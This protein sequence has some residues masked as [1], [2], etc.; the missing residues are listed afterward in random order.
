MQDRGTG[1]TAVAVQEGNSDVVEVRLAEGTR[2][3]QVLLNQEVLSFAEQ[4]WMDLKGE[5]DGL[6]PF[7][8]HLGILLTILV[9]GRG[10]LQGTDVET[11]LL[12]LAAGQ[13]SAPLPCTPSE[14]PGTVDMWLWPVAICEQTVLGPR[15]QS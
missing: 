14:G 15:Q 10:C 6:T 4:S 2:V 5:W 3:L 11:G 8:F 12:G 13:P 7:A 1:L 9:G